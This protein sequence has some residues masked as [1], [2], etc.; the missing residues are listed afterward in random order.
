MVNSYY[1]NI[2]V[3][4]KKL[5]KR[6]YSFKKRII[7]MNAHNCYSTN[8][9]KL[10]ICILISIVFVALNSFSQ[11]RCFFV[12]D[13]LTNE[14][15]PYCNIVYGDGQGLITNHLGEFCIKTNERNTLLTISISNISYHQ[16]SHVGNN[17]N[18]IIYLQ[19]KQYKLNS[20]DVN[21][22]N[23][24][25]TWFGNTLKQPD[26]YI[27]LWRF[28]QTGIYIPPMKKN[29][30]ILESVSVP[31]QNPNKVKVPFRLHIYKADSLLGVA[32]ELLPENVYGQVLMKDYELIELDILKYQITIP[33]NGVFVTIE[34]LS[35][36]KPNELQVITGKY[37]E[38]YNNNNRIGVTEA[39]YRHRKMLK[40]SAWKTNS[41]YI[42]QYPFTNAEGIY[43]ELPM[44]KVK[45]RQIKN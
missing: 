27:N 22:S 21:W 2:L 12:I 13:T 31:I 37:S 3:Q 26:S 23:Y 19:P 15:I 9:Y 39:R 18:S 24:R 35:N 36:N 45:V 16:K 40:I 38:R 5:Q 25:F 43:G 30:G 4:W 20:I 14:P 44:I 34:L 17:N 1:S 41:F 10:R 29:A 6:I 8:Y 32:E 7:N 33:E 11:N 42:E 28:C